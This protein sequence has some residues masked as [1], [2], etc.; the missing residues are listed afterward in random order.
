[1]RVSL[2][3]GIAAVALLLAGCAPTVALEPA[4]DAASPLCAE[5]TVRLP[6]AIDEFA[7]RETNAQAT[8]AW[9]QPVAVV[10]HCGVPTPAPTAEFPCVTVEGIDWL[11]D[12]TDAPSYVFTSYG[13]TPAVEV[14]VDSDVASGLDAL[15]ALAPAVGRLPVEGAC[16]TPEG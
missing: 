5:V 15:T 3:L 6:D 7:A 1:M 11:R 8:G 10:L 12:D 16:I 9:G 14:V 2:P 13:R 4:D